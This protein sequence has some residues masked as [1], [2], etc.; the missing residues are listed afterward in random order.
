[1]NI[2]TAMMSEQIVLSSELMQICMAIVHVTGSN[3]IE[4]D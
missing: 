1:M 2:M 3:Q 4:L